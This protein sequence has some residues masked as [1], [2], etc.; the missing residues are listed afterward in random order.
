MVHAITLAADAEGVDGEAFLIGDEETLSWR[1]FVAPIATA[2]G[3]SVDDLPT[4]LADAAERLGVRL[5]EDTTVTAFDREDGAVVVRTEWG[6]VRADRVVIGTGAFWGPLKR[7]ALWTLPVYD[8]VLMSEPLSAAQLGAVGWQGSEGLTDAGN[9]FH[10][11]RRTLDDRVLFSE[12]LGLVGRPDRIERD[13]EFLIPEEWKPWAKRVY[14]PH[15]LQLA[16][17]FLLVEEGFGVRPPH[18]WVVIRDGERVKVQNTE[19]LRAEALAIAEEIREHRRAIR[20]EVPVRQPA[21]RG[22]NR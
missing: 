2:L 7:L 10:Y 9:Q 12:R 5:H 20:E 8:H 21:R 18:G 11:Y 4:L 13:G 19:Q 3:V 6:S 17:Y 16:V 1:S 14:P 22:S 15:R